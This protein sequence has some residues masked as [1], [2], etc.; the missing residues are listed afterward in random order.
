MPFNILRFGC[1]CSDRETRPIINTNPTVVVGPTGAA[2]PIG[3]T[4]PTGPSGTG[5]TGPTGP[6]GPTG[7]TGPTG[8]TGPTGATGETINENATIYNTAEQS[9]T[10]NTALTLPTELTNNGLTTTTANTIIV[11][12]AGTYEVAF[13]TATATGAGANDNVALALNGSILEPTRRP[14]SSSQGATGVYVYNLAADSAL[15]LVPTVTGATT[16]VATNGPSATL[17]VIR[18]G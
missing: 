16:L 18:L 2:G 13:T 12:E 7:A 4:G 8:P 17:T 9:L 14:L 10:T 5:I 11:P 1:G 15:T 3:P 6:T